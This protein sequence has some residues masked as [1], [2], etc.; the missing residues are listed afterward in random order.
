MQYLGARMTT[1]HGAAITVPTRTL[2]DKGIILVFKLMILTTLLCSKLLQMTFDTF[3]TSLGTKSFARYAGMFPHVLV[4][5]VTTDNTVLR[6]TREANPANWPSNK[7]YEYSH[8]TSTSSLRP[9]IEKNHLEL[10]LN[11]AK[12]EGWRILL[13]G[14]VSQAR[15]QATSGAASPRGD[16]A[17]RFDERTFHQHILNF[18]VADDQV[19]SHLFMFIM[20]IFASKSLNI[21]ECHEFRQLLLL[22]RHDLK[23]ELIPHRTKVRELVIQAWRQHFQILRR[24]LAV[25]DP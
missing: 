16:R 2:L 23:E 25:C 20:L 14:L 3:S 19:C 6:E 5:L 13:P 8:K 10:Y 12:E 7:Q 9:H 1:R 17:D 21:V 18:I 4:S 15:S 22:L 24:D 11:L